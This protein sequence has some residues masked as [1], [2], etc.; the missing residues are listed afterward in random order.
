MFPLWPTWKC[1]FSFPLTWITY[2]DTNK[3]KCITSTVQWPDN[4]LSRL[5]SPVTSTHPFLKYGLLLENFTPIE[6]C[7]YIHGT[8]KRKR[9]GFQKEICLGLEGRSFNFTDCLHCGP[10]ESQTGW[11]ITNGPQWTLQGGLGWR[12]MEECWNSWTHGS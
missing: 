6:H 2:T 9:K 10:I 1:P 7:T 3:S 8:I 11:S 4:L 12:W 5:A